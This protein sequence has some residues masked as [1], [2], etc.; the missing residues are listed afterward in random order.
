MSGSKW[1]KLDD[2]RQPGMRRVLEALQQVR[3][4][5]AG[6]GADQASF[7][8]IEQASLAAVELAKRHGG[9][10]LPT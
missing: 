9:G 5:A 10:R 3:A 7:D 4:E 2:L 6:D 1:I 8:L